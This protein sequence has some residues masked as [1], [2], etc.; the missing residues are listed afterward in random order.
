MLYGTLAEPDIRVGYAKTNVITH[1][2][3]RSFLR[4]G[5]KVCETC[6]EVWGKEGCSTYREA[7]ALLLTAPSTRVGYRRLM[8]D[9]RADRRST[10]DS[11]T[12]SRQ[13][14]RSGRH[15]RRPSPRPRMEHIGSGVY[16]AA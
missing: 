4:F 13:A 5:V 1:S 7:I 16:R 11:R 8:D 14:K 15:A 2:P 3:I 12:R 6:G 10:G 9:I